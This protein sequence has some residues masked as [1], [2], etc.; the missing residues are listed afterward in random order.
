MVRGPFHLHPGGGRAGPE[1]VGARPGGRENRAMFRPRRILV[2]VEPSASGEAVVRSAA[3]MARGFGARILLFHVFDSRAVEDVY[4]LHGLK[5]EEVR[6]R[7]KANAEAMIERLLGRPWLRG[8]R[9]STKLVY[10]LPPE[11]IVAEAEAWKAD[12]VVLSKRRRSGLSPL[13]YG[14]TSDAV[15]REAGCAVLVLTS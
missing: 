2:P 13:L 15:V 5:E 3:E 12:L 10:G 4:N 11:A 14:R 9:V 1:E 6:A 7:M 8:L